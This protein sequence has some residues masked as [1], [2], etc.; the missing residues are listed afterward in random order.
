VVGLGSL[1]CW[2]EGVVDV[3][4]ARPVLGAEV[5]TEYLHVPAGTTFAG[6]LQQ[7]AKVKHCLQSI[8]KNVRR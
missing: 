4:G 8:L 3:D 6:Q 2:Q 1:E 7:E 5:L